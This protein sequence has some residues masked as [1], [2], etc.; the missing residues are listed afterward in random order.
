MG[1][2][3]KPDIPEISCVTENNDIQHSTQYNHVTWKDQTAPGIHTDITVLPVNPE[4]VQKS[5]GLKYCTHLNSR[6]QLI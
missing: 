3:L 2:I 1:L 4:R 5:Q 6:H